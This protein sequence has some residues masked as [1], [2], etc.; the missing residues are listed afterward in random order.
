MLWQ[1]EGVVTDEGLI[2]TSCVVNCTGA[3]ANQI[4]SHVGLQVPLGENSSFFLREKIR[5]KAD[6]YTFER[7]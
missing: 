4:C 2:K 1:V 5:K 3:W 7:S 6:R